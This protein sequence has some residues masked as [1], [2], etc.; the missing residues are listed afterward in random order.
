MHIVFDEYM[1]WPDKLGLE[2]ELCS[3][4]C[5][6]APKHSFLVRVQIWRRGV[7]VI[8]AGTFLHR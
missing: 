2:A 8:S 3:K 6:R 5:K 7:G 4:K 1:P